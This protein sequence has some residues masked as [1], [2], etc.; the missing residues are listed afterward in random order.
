MS[1]IVFL[2]VGF[3]IGLPEFPGKNCS[4]VENYDNKLHLL[5][6]RGGQ[7]QFLAKENVV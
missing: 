6:V 7:T 5:L 2:Q 3:N 1:S 4:R